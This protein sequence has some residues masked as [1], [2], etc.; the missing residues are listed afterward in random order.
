MKK[1]IQPILTALGYYTIKKKWRWHQYITRLQK[2]DAHRKAEAMAWI[3][4]I[5]QRLLPEVKKGGNVTVSLTSHSKRVTDF[6][7]FAIYSIF[8]QTIMPN[9]IVLNINQEK[10]TDENLPELIKKLQIAGLEVNLCEDVGPHTKLL[11]ALEKYPDDIII[12]VD[13]DIYYDKY[14]IEDLMTEYRLHA[15]CV[16]CRDALVIGITPLGLLPYSD[17]Q[18]ATT[19]DTSH[20]LPLGVNGVLYAPH[21]FNKEVSN[22][23]VYSHLC[24]KAD[25]IWFMIQEVLQDIPVYVTSVSHHRGSSSVD[26]RN[27]Y[28]E[29][30]SNALH[31]Q[32]TQHGGNDMQLSNLIEH[33]NLMFKL[34]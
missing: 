6:A 16:V 32:N 7:P 29:K 18:V 1:Y 15:S 12:T 28:V 13:D 23:S 3:E 26:H 34:K 2:E 27:E 4:A 22:K 19:N 14:L 21:V 33:Y 8:H 30:G 24:S 9:R 5:D 31:F 20:K 11:P 10:W 17:W 25:D